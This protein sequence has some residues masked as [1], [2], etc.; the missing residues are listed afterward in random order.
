MRTQRD[1]GA[2]FLFAWLDD[3][4]LSGVEHNEGDRRWAVALVAPA[5][6]R[7]LLERRCRQPAN[8]LAC[9]HPTLRR[10]EPRS[11]AEPKSM[12]SN[13]TDLRSFVMLE[14][15][16]HWPPLEAPDATSAALVAYLQS[17]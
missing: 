10:A 6:P 13:L 4:W 16:G 8:G 14:R 1:I 11:A 12:R 9:H 2:A 17:L 3:R 7:R 5:M 15:V